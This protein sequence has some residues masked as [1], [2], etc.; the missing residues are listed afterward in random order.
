[1]PIQR[2]GQGE[3]KIPSME[4]DWAKIAEE[5]KAIDEK[6][7]GVRETPNPRLAK[8][9]SGNMYAAKAQNRVKFLEEDVPT[10][11]K[12]AQSPAEQ[13][14]P[15]KMR[16]KHDPENFLQGSK[17]VSPA[18]Y[19]NITENG[20]PKKFIKGESSP[21]IFDTEKLSR[22]ARQPSLKEQT[23]VNKAAEKEQRRTLREERTKQIVDALQE[24]DQRKSSS[25][26]PSGDQQVSSEQSRFGHP[27]GGIS[28]FDHDA[29]ERLPELT[30]GEKL[31]KARKEKAAKKDES[32]KEG[33]R[34]FS[35]KDVLTRFVG[36]L[37]KDK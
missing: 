15:K 35:T 11:D 37:E 34:S 19:G 9:T 26:S 5:V 24:V 25:V 7:N 21:T 29:F 1:M 6:H 2:I 32:W 27:R 14:L 3:N 36:G 23:E 28:I 16:A 20:G 31:S 33:G 4:I 30:A 10:P 18:Y 17:S 13:S 12:V 22:L 8:Q